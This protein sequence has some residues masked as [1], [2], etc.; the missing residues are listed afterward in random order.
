MLTKGYLDVNGT[1]LVWARRGSSPNQRWTFSPIP[2]PPGALVQWTP[3]IPLPLITVSAALLTDGTVL[4]W[5]AA[6]VDDYTT[7]GSVTLF[8]V[9]DTTS[10]AATLA[11]AGIKANMFCPGLVKLGDGS[12]FVAGGVTPAATGLYNGSWQPSSPLRIPRGYNAA[13]TLST[14]DVFTVGGAWSGGR[15]YKD[16]ELWSAANQT[17]RIL[18][19]VPAR[20][21][22]TADAA[23]AYRSDLGLRG[24]LLPATASDSDHS[25]SDYYRVG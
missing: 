12:V 8:S 23:G 5:M 13:V 24:G 19:K 25:D 16:G 22:S 2:T 9:I 18:P 11:V 20:P 10:G 6:S 7:A 15:T 4:S 1:A 21:L 17:W 3:P 14:G